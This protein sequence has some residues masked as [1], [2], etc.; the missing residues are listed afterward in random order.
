METAD[1]ELRIVLN[2]STSIFDYNEA[3]YHGML[4]GLLRN[5]AI[6]RSN[7]EYGEGRPDI[8]AIVEGKGIILEI[9]CVTPKSLEQAKKS[10]PNMDEDD[11]VDALVDKKL[12]E[13]ENQMKDRKYIHAVLRHEPLAREVVAYV[14]CFC[15]KWCT[16]RAVAVK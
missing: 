2:D 12:I 14:V 6:V 15:R 4:V 16:M 8:V 7:D 9:K 1:R 11:L 13:A 5:V 3:F 10:H